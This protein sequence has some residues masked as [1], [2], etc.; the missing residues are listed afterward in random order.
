MG[1]EQG[2]GGRERDDHHQGPRSGP[3]GVRAQRAGAATT[4]LVV[5][6]VGVG[7]LRGALV[8]L[9]E[10]DVACG[11]REAERR[12]VLRERAECRGGRGAGRGGGE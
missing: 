11:L 9:L 12:R 8:R 4:H 7:G 1:V 5:E 6:G 10:G 3:G 2:R